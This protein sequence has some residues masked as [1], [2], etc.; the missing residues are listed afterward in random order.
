MVFY[1]S[2]LILIARGG[3]VSRI[4]VVPFLF[5]KGLASASCMCRMLWSYAHLSPCLKQQQQEQQQHSV[6]ILA[7]VTEKNR[8]VILVA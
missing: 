3:D 2:S 1:F 4:M 7:Q 6:A 8:Q 5:V